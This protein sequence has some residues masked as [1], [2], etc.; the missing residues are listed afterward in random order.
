M[1]PRIAFDR[2]AIAV[3]SP[4]GLLNRKGGISASNSVAVPLAEAAKNAKK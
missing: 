2:D 4:A 1:R 3:V